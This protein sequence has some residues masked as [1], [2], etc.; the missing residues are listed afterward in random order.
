MLAIK[1]K[2]PALLFKMYTSLEFNLSNL[3]KQHNY[4]SSKKET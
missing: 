3:Y 1:N 4:G 2:N